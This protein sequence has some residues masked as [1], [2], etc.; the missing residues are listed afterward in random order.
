MLRTVTKARRIDHLYYR[1][2]GNKGEGGTGDTQ[3][4]SVESASERPQIEATL[5]LG[6]AL[7]ASATHTASTRN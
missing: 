5:C 2:L 3:I 1:V 4:K 7:Y 6:F